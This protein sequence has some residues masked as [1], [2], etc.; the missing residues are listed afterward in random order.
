MSRSYQAGGT[1]Y[2]ARFAAMPDTGGMANDYIVVQ[3]SDST[4][5]T[6]VGITAPGDRWAPG[7]PFDGPVSP[8]GAPSGPVAMTGQDVFIAST[9]E[10]ANIE[11]GAA[12]QSG[13][14]LTWDTF[15]RAI[16]CTSGNW[17]AA[18]ALETASG[19]GVRIK[20]QCM[21]CAKFP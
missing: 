4:K 19:A 2:P 10:E 5:G 9:P 1:I 20:V 3:A 18:R 11:S 6:V 7:T 13:D 12:V 14:L 8:T 16:T 17:Y 21:D 15:G